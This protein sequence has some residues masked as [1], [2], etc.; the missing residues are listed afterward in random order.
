MWEGHPGHPSGEPN[1]IVIFAREHLGDI[2][3]TIPALR[4]IRRRFPNARITLEAGEKTLGLL[5]RCPYVDHLWARPTHQGLGGKLKFIWRLRQGRFDM[6]IILDNSNDMVLHA[7]LGGIPKRYGIRKNKFFRLFTASVPFDPSKHE[8]LDH[9]REVVE[10]VGCDTSDWRLELFP[11]E[12]AFESARQILQSEGWTGGRPLIGFNPGAS[13]VHRRW[14]PERFTEVAERLLQQTGGQVVILGAKEE[15]E[16]GQQIACRMQ[17]KPCLL[18]GKLT[19]DELIAVLSFLDILVTNDSGPMHLAAAVGTPVVALFGFTD[20][21][22]TGPLGNHHILIRKVNDCPTCT[23]YRCTQQRAC[24]SLI[25]VE[26]VVQ[27]VLT[28]LRSSNES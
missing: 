16:L 2:V 18:T 1:R 14:F 21:R 5:Q 11:D 26:E 28:I 4:A 12:S 22:R 9:L 13:E 7:Y 3:C 17:A 15:R 27:A 25:E 8:M 20:P 10:L 23:H 19:L 24:M 6:A